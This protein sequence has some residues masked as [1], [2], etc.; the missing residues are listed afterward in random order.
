MD[1]SSSCCL[2][3]EP[4][5]LGWPA[6]LPSST[7]PCELEGSSTAPFWLP[8]P[9]AV[10]SCC[11]APLSTAA[12]RPPDRNLGSVGSNAKCWLVIMSAKRGSA[13]LGL[14]LA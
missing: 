8:G 14:K 13:R 9:P 12:L 1:F 2:E 6:L 7:G 3:R 4:A 10:P 5:P 11:G